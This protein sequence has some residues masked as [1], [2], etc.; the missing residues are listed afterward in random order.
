M[1]AV[2]LTTIVTGLLPLEL[3]YNLA[4]LREFDAEETSLEDALERILAYDELVELPRD[5]QFDPV[6]QAKRRAKHET[7][8]RTLL[9][10]SPWKTCNC[11]ICNEVGV[12]VVIFRGNNRNRRR[13]F[14]NTYAF[15]ER[16]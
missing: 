2:R 16:F 6:A 10:D 5:G 3:L 11:L 13:G 8:Y 12:E 15:Y 1:I 9:Q 7:M 14:H 4:I